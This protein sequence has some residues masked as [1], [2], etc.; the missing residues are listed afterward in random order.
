MG[1]ARGVPAPVPPMGKLI[2]RAVINVWGKDF[3]DMYA[4]TNSR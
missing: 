1:L 4:L 3:A 2:V